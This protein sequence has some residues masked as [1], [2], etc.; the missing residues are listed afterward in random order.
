MILNLRKWAKKI[1][2][3]IQNY[4]LKETLYLILERSHGQVVKGEETSKTKR[5]RV[6]ILEYDTRRNESEVANTVIEK[7]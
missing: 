3:V 1:I 4:P 5:A 6:Q 2:G 7:K